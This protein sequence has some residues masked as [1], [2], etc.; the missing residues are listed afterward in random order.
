MKKISL[1]LPTRARPNL[2]MECVLSF[3][4]KAAYPERLE[5]VVVIDDDDESNKE[6]ETLA[7]ETGITV[8]KVPRSNHHQRDY[9][10]LAARMTTGEYIWGLNDDTEI[11]TE[12]WDVLLEASIERFIEEKGTRVVY[13]A[14][15]DQTHVGDYQKENGCCFPVI[16]REFYEKLGFFMPDEIA[17]WGGDIILYKITQQANVPILWLPELKLLHKTYHNGTRMPDS[18]SEHVHFISQNT[19][20]HQQAMNEYARRLAT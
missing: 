6:F 1:F 12:G 9:N 18:I 3:Y 10:N 11:A 7:S 13:V 5:M 15:D 2:L 8:L 16:T 20:V 19:V 4:E 17:S 14:M